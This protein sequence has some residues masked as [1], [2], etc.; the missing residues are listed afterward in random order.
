MSYDR[1]DWHTDT[2]AEKSLPEENAATHIAA[3]VRWCIQRNLIA[4][5][6]AKEDSEVLE[7]VRKG[8]LSAATYFDE[9]M[10]WK[11]GEWNLNDV[12]NQFTSAY[13]ESYLADLGIFFPNVVYGE[14]ESIDFD[15]LASFLDVKF[16]EFKNGNLKIATRKGKSWWKFW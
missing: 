3:Y 8:E 5:E 7:Q 10:D 9:Y 11:F 12:G 15:R 16:N 4:E 2:C 1:A 6:I 14:W 13:Y